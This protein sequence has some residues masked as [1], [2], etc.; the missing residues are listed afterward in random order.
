MATLPTFFRKT[1]GGPAG[2]RIPAAPKPEIV[3]DLFQLRALPFEDVFFQSKAIDNAR[4][5]READPRTAGRCRSAIGAACL[6]LALCGAGMAPRMANRIAGYKLEELR[7]AERQ[8]VD[9]SR[10]LQLR[11]AELLGPGKLEQ[12]ARERNLALPSPGQV[13]NLE[14]KSEGAMAMAKQ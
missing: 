1:D 12:L 2:P 7:A 3:R 11:E 6:T 13:V 9:Q 5:V 14:P 10:A 4:L 8:L